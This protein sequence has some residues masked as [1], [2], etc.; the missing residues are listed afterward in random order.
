MHGNCGHVMYIFHYCSIKASMPG[1]GFLLSIF[2][3]IC[4]G[5]IRQE[6]FSPGT[7]H[8]HTHTHSEKMENYSH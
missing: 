2:H 7:M 3:T 6:V 1:S 5:G 4:L 8:T